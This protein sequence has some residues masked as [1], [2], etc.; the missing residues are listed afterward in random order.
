MP[1]VLTPNP[2][3]GFFAR[4]RDWFTGLS[5]N[6]KI[7]VGCAGLI[8]VCLVCGL[9]NSAI[10]AVGNGGHSST[11]RSNAETVDVHA[12]QT[13]Q[14]FDNERR[15]ALAAAQATEAAKPTAT[16]TSP[17]QWVTVQHFSGT[18]AY[19]SPTF[20]VS[21]QWRIVWS[22][23]VNNAY[24]G[25]NFIVEAYT[26]D[27]SYLDLVANTVGNGKGEWNGHQDGDIY[28]KVNTFGETWSVDVQVY[29]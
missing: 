2:T 9:C 19:Q 6:G 27:G 16:P 21:G 8:V 28:L 5:R 14:E 11:A 26:S 7:G 20:T 29:Q 18:A 17:P 23:G 12:T 3:T 1:P 4:L 24:G 15:I 25:G 10:G 13:A 22:C